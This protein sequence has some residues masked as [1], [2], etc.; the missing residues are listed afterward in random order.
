[1][2]S[3]KT[4]RLEGPLTLHTPLSKVLVKKGGWVG[5]ENCKASGEPR[6]EAIRDKAAEFNGS[7]IF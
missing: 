1:M 3:V 5:V 2:E 6:G 4:L 7:K